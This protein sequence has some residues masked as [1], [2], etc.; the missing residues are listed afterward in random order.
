MRP[1]RA[2]LCSEVVHTSRDFKLRVQG[3]ARGLPRKDLQ[4]TPPAE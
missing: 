2:T 3:P 1:S 4:A